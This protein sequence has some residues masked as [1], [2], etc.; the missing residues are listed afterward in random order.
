MVSSVGLALLTAEESTFALFALP[1][2]L[3]NGRWSLAIFGKIFFIGSMSLPFNYRFCG[4]EETIFRPWSIT[5][6]PPIADS[7]NVLCLLSQ[8]AFW[9]TSQDTPGPGTF[10]SFRT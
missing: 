6:W 8:D 5:S 3:S 1:I 9:Q 2:A 10:G 4:T 7:W